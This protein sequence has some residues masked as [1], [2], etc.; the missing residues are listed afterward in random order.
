MKLT[1]LY[2]GMNTDVLK[3]GNKYQGEVIHIDDNKRPQAI[4]LYAGTSVVVLQ[5]QA[6][7]NIKVVQED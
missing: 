1:F 5:N 6:L 4:R 7:K 2:T 3:S